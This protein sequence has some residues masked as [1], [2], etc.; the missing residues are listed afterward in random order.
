MSPTRRPTLPTVQTVGPNAWTDPNW[1]YLHSPQSVQHLNRLIISWTG[2]TNSPAIRI[3]LTLSVFLTGLKENARDLATI[4]NDVLRLAGLSDRSESSL[5]DAMITWML[6]NKLNYL[7]DQWEKILSPIATPALIRYTYIKWDYLN[8]HL[9][10][11]TN[12]PTDSPYTLNQLTNYLRNHWTGPWTISLD[13]SR[14]ISWQLV[15]GPSGALLDDVLG[16]F[17][18]FPDPPRGYERQFYLW[19]CLSTQWSKTPSVIVRNASSWCKQGI[20]C[21][22]KAAQTG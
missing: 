4:L 16:L 11:S 17:A 13:W 8:H 3:A 12:S 5:L 2:S 18:N 1:S 9:D 19:Y 21:C 10:Q 22:Y 15:G 14:T 20:C 7:K 6:K